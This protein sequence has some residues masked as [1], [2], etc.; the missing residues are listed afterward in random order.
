MADKTQNININYKFNTAA[1]DKATA[2]LDKANAATNKLQ[3]SA[4]GKGGSPIFKEF[5]N[6][7]KTILNM[8]NTLTSLKS[9]IDITSDPKKLAQLSREYGVV[10]KSLDETTKSVYGLGKATKDSDQSVK[11]MVTSFKNLSVVAGAALIAGI[12][13]EVVNL[14]LEMSTL[15]G[16]VE[17]VERGFNRAFADP[18]RILNEVREATQ[19]TITDFDLMKRTLQA[20]NLGVSVEHLGTLFEFAAARAQQ[21]GESVDYLVDS[22]VRGI[23]RKSPLVLDNLGISVTA[24]K[25]KFDG[26]SIASKT[27]AE[28]TEGVAEIAEEQ[29]KKMGGF[30]ET[31]ETR[32]KRLGVAW[33]DVRITLAKKID[34]AGVIQFFTD[35]AKGLE[36][37]IKGGETLRKEDAKTI[38]QQ[39]LS[40]LL[41][42]EIFK[43]K[44][45][46]QLLQLDLITQEIL[47]T[48]KLINAKER[49]IREFEAARTAA[50][51]AITTDEFGNVVA[52]QSVTFRE[53]AI[54]GLKRQK[55]AYEELLPMLANALRVTQSQIEL[56]ATV[57]KNLD[58]MRKELAS[59]V[60]E[61][62]SYATSQ[63]KSTEEH[64]AQAV[65]IVK[66][67]HEIEAI[68]A[69]LKD[70]KTLK[71]K[72]EPIDPEWIKT[73]ERIWKF[74][75]EGG[76]MKGT[77]MMPDGHIFDPK[78][79]AGRAST[80]VID[81][82]AMMEGTEESADQIAD[83][84]WTRLRLAMKR[85]GEGNE[86]QEDLEDAI[87]GLQMT[88]VDILSD[89]LMSIADVEADTYARRI[90]QTK[91]FFD[92][93]QIIAGNN[94]RAKDQLRLIENRK[95]EVLRRKQF[96][97]EQRA[98]RQKAL[99]DGAAAILKTF[100][101]YGFTP[102]AAIAAAGMAAV[103]LSQIN[104]INRQ[105]PRFAKGVIG[106]RG[107]GT[108]TSDSIPAQLSNGESVMTAWETK[109]AGN[110]LKEIRAKK[111]N[112]KVLQG[113][114]QGR[115]P[116][117]NQ[118][119][120]N[121]EKIIKAIKDNRPPDITLQSGIVYEGRKKSE[122]YRNKVRAKS[123]RI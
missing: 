108:G 63:N 84:F 65:V 55:A 67:R 50:E 25:E 106:L 81:V 35:V 45:S 99:I 38:A 19:G 18:G 39:R 74:F 94:E 32:V 33:E 116:V 23:G 24:L 100:A 59:L 57:T 60:E 95:I 79:A 8:T 20:T 29:L 42:D 104:I 16:Q 2:S 21:T 46:N 86:M 112:D 110:V 4:S 96:I 34:A 61:Y 5:Q 1:I 109:H 40:A 102:A 13:K 43:D 10:K 119:V 26:A 41:D 7:E 80:E 48:Q 47:A 6:S 52:Q 44:K 56:D 114:K 76:T 113:L 15:Q 98:A 11:G 75:G 58:E 103:T 70:P 68:E 3:Q 9:Q 54:D 37:I 62:D 115:M 97:A 49:E 117:Q 77:T 66:L 73:M 93:L 105:T 88:G 28:A 90:K 31:A 14:T 83:S 101:F 123:I 12:T 118:V 121:D 87:I 111:L 30:L 122:E 17:G 78:E 72:V 36:V 53:K 22:I 91:N 82:D 71:V 85:Q 51:K 27:V 64:R 89:Q 69:L 107:K 120:F 92:Q